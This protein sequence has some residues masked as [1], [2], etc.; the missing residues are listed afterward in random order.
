MLN[1][2]VAIVD[3]FSRQSKI[4]EV[5]IH[6]YEVGP[7]GE[8]ILYKGEAGE[9]VIAPGYWGSVGVEKVKE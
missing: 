7:A 6:S 4:M 1:A 3:P 2:T 8:L 5:R 9:S